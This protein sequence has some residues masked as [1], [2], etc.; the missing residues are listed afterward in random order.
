L[1]Y[2]QASA[3]FWRGSGYFPIKNN[4]VKILFPVWGLVISVA[5]L[6]QN[7]RRNDYNNINWLQTVNTIAVSKKWS[8]HLE[9]QARRTKGWKNWQQ[10]LLRTGINYKMHEHITVH[11][12]YAW[13]ETFAYGDFP[14]ASSGTFPEHRLYEQISFRQPVNNWVF[15]HRFRIEQRWLGRV[16][17]AP[18]REIESWNFLHRFRYQFRAQ[19]PLWSKKEQQ[20]FLA[21][22]DEVLIGAGKNVGV[23]IFDQNRILLLAGYKFS[24][25][26]SLEA[27]YLNQTLQQGKKMNDQTIMQRNNGTMLSAILSF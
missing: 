13:I 10:S 22:A 4:M 20:F 23:N 19:V 15:T 7:D 8:V 21:A 1:N 12:G 9:Y 16:K 24:N 26:F 2:I 14:I 27:G 6:A 18:G 3:A 25:R 5:A 11:L 17:A